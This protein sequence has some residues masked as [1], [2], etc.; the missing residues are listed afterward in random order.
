M[1]DQMNTNEVAAQLGTD[2][3]TL[4]RFIRSDACPFPAVGS[5]G[6]YSFDAKDIPALQQEFNRWLSGQES[7]IKRKRTKMTQYD[8][9]QQVW[10]EEGPVIIP[11]IRNPRVRADVRRRAAERAQRLDE[12]LMVAGLHISQW[13][14]RV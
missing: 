12:M 10:E 9:D 14:D 2:P 7:P 13:R 11:D 5:G 3:K 1:G 6:R 4:R 8:K